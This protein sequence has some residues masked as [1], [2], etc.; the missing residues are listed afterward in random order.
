MSSLYRFKA[1]AAK[2][3]LDLVNQGFTEF[4]IEDFH[5]T[6]SCNNDIFSVDILISVNVCLHCGASV[7]FLL[8][9]ML[10]FH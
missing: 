8:V 6:V 1:V 4:T 9:V 10:S 7:M 5:N 3:K 2:S